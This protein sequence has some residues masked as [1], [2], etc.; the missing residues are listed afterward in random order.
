[1]MGKQRTY[2]ELA[3][4]QPG[5][6]KMGSRHCCWK[7]RGRIRSGISPHSLPHVRAEVQNTCLPGV[8]MGGGTHAQFGRLLRQP[9]S[10]FVLKVYEG[11]SQPKPPSGL[12]R[13]F[14]AGIPW[15]LG[16]LSDGW[17]LAG[18]KPTTHRPRLLHGQMWGGIRDK[19]TAQLRRE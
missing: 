19:D 13:L 8:G 3:Q 1:M 14:F 7:S 5:R 9:S 16:T 10:Y 2:C 15:S 4:T 11:W 18:F 12:D 6:L 17:L